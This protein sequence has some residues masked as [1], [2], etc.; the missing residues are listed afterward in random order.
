MFPAV[1]GGILVIDGGGN[2]GSTTKAPF[3]ST[4]GLD[5]VEY[6]D[7]QLGISASMQQ[8]Q[9]EQLEQLEQQYERIR[10]RLR[11]T[12]KYLQKRLE[13]ELNDAVRTSSSRSFANSN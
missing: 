13:D 10:S 12:R 4:C 8:E 2:I 1:Q 11:K 6:I 9:Q 7:S 5:F 3:I